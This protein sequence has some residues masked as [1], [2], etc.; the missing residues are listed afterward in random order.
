MKTLLRTSILVTVLAS[1]ALMS[2]RATSLTGTCRTTCTK[3]STHTIVS[4][5]ATR[6]QCCGQTVNPCPAGYTATTSTFTPTGG[7]TG[8]CPA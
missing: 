4:W 5:S 8:I 2:G 6:A 7:S 3:G 1:T